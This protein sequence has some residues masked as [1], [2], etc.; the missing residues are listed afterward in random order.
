[1]SSRVAYYLA[2]FAAVLTHNTIFPVK[3]QSTEQ[4]C[5]NGGDSNSVAAEL[6]VEAFRHLSN[7]IQIMR[8]L[9]VESFQQWKNMNESFRQIK[10]QQD[11]VISTLQSVDRRLQEQDVYVQRIE[12]IHEVLNASFQQAKVQQD[13]V[14]SSLQSVDRRL[15]SQVQSIHE[16]LNESFRQMKD[17]HARAMMRLDVVTKLLLYSDIT[18]KNQAESSW[19]LAVGKVNYVYRTL[20]THSLN[21]TVQCTGPQK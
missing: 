16:L 14:I 8:E 20:K 11:N 19:Q 18:V 1:M 12:S 7:Q 13:N 17:Q 2:A 6:N 9:L 21:F 15:Q 5:G 10:N 4:C 3:S